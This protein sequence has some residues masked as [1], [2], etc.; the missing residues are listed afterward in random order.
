MTATIEQ[1]SSENYRHIL[2]T[3]KLNK[4]SFLRFSEKSNTSAVY[5]RHD[6]DYS[7]EL[8]VK[9][10]K[11]NAEMDVIGT[12][13]LLLRTPSY[14]LLS[15][16]SLELA[17]EII[18]HGQQIALH[19]AMPRQVPETEIEFSKLIMYD[20][21]LL[22][23][24]LPEATP[25][26]AWHN[27]TSDVIKRGFDLQIDGLINAY[28]RDF[29]K[30]MPYHSDSNFRTSVAEFETIIQDNV[31]Q[32]IHLL[33]H[34]LNWIVGGNNMLD[35]LAKTWQT[36]I[37]EQEKEVLKNRVYRGFFPKGM[38][39]ET[40]QIFTDALTSSVSNEDNDAI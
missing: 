34:P 32:S 22:K 6:V 15:A 3:L 23:H 12:F 18:N 39:D 29:L 17:E 21:N 10:A 19:Y 8:A 25:L 11:I 37:R 5:L 4:Y 38:S 9:L 26:F 33:F 7:L 14:N 13:C 28:S 35:I 1:Y 27:P 2:Q 20:F 31:G 36:M 16:E 40:L 24:H 30:N